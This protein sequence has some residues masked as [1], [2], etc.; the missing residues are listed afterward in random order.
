MLFFVSSGAGWGGVE[1][2]G[3]AGGPRGGTTARTP[4]RGG[5]GGAN[6]RH[7]FR[8]PARTPSVALY[9]TT[10]L[11]CSATTTS[12]S[13]N[14][15]WLTRQNSSREHPRARGRGTQSLA[16][17]LR[18][19]ALNDHRLTERRAAVLARGST[20]RYAP[21]PGVPNW[22][23]APLNAGAPGAERGPRRARGCFPARCLG[24]ATHSRPPLSASA[25]WPTGAPNDRRVQLS[26]V[27]RI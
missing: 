21:G 3:G 22:P 9:L 10:R 2:F 15:A 20:P 5:G 25:F 16:K 19:P 26:A 4:G 13:P 23:R 27:C 17:Q 7:H 8:A 12:A 1:G 6:R 18:P 24:A 14:C 11:C